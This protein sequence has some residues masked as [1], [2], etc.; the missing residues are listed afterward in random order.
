MTKKLRF[1]G[2]NSVPYVMPTSRSINIDTQLD[3]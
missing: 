1:G 3:F 2:D